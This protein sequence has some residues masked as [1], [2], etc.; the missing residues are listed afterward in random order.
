MSRYLLEIPHDSDKVACTKAIR[1]LLESGSHFLSNADWGCA[2]GDHRAWLVVDVGSRE[3]AQSILPPELR[4]GARIVRLIKFVVD[5]GDGRVRK[6][7]A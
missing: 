3:E 4:P 1:I 7:E 2:D 6:R 5:P